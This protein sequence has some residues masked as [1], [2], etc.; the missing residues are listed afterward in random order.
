MPSYV[1]FFKLPF[2]AIISMIILSA[3]LIAAIVA[4]V[5]LTFVS[6]TKR[7]LGIRPIVLRTELR[8]FGKHKL[9]GHEMIKIDNRRELI[10]DE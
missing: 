8:T 10:V 4:S 9:V 2:A 3:A 1:S 6:K 5:Y 7:S